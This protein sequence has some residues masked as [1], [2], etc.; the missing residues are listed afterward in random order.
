MILVLH[1]M[2]VFISCNSREAGQINSEKDVLQPFL[3]QKMKK[4]PNVRD[5]ALSPGGKEIYFTVDS[6]KKDF[7]FIATMTLVGEEWSLPRIAD[8]SGQYKELEPAFSP[9]GLQL[10]YASKRP[11]T[12]SDS[13][14]KTDYDIWYVKRNEIRSNWSKPINIGFPINTEGN[15]FYPSIALSGN[16]Y[17]TAER[18]DSKGREDIYL[19]TKENNKYSEPVSLDTAI[20]TQ[21]FEFNAYVSPDE[22]LIVFSSYGREDG[23]GGGDLY[24]SIKDENN[25]WNASRNAGTNINSPQLDYCPFVDYT[26]GKLFFSSERNT[27]NYNGIV[28]KS[29]NE[30]LLKMNQYGNGMCRIYSINLAETDI[31]FDLTRND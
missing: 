7:S 3:P 13:T 19:S 5:F 22:S 18:H 12:D 27:I 29:I 11:I 28:A 14:E 10:Y 24:Y 20:N 6:Y 26:N 16:L 2:L 15:E 30:I 4:F 17:F 23:M 8:F 1:L 31:P 9:D 25:Q 21:Y